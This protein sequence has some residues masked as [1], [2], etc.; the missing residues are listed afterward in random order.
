MISTSLS[1]AIWP[2]PTAPAL[3]PSTP[4][5]EPPCGPAPPPPEPGRIPGMPQPFQTPRILRVGG[6]GVA[7]GWRETPGLPLGKPQLANAGAKPGLQPTT[8]LRAHAPGAPIPSASGGPL[9]KE[10]PPHR[11]KFRVPARG[12]P[13][14]TTHSL[15]PGSSSRSSPFHAHPRPPPVGTGGGA[16]AGWGRGAHVPAP[17]PPR[18]G[19]ESGARSPPVPSC[20]RQHSPF[21]RSPAGRRPSGKPRDRTGKVREQAEPRTDPRATKP[22]RPRS[23]RK[24]KAWWSPPGSRG[25]HVTSRGG[26]GRGGARAEAAAAPRAAWGRAPLECG[27]GLEGAGLARTQTQARAATFPGSRGLGYGRVT[28]GYHFPS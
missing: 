18:Q 6:A 1:S 2:Q 4:S 26:A 8:G 27:R 16:A 28:I 14:H 20:S 22:R 10:P 7:T 15:D 9:G 24:H 19:P 17:P 5:P 11:P 21:P 12:L 3:L 25:P 13:G 23:P